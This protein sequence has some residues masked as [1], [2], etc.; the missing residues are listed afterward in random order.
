MRGEDVLGRIQ[1]RPEW[2]NL[3]V[4]VVSGLDREQM[5]KPVD[6]GHFF[7]KPL[8]PQVLVNMLNTDVCAV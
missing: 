7:Q 5:D 8:N 2:E 6:S 4:Y 1:R 3:P